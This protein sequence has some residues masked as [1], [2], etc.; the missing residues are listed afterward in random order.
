MK[1]Q[2]MWRHYSEVLPSDRTPHISLREHPAVM[3]RKL[4]SAA[5]IQD[6]Q[7]PKHM[8]KSKKKDHLKIGVAGTLE[9]QS[10]DVTWYGVTGTPT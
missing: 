8:I 10:S 1:H 2:S 7:D 9:Q 4:Y 5:C 3:Q 6:P